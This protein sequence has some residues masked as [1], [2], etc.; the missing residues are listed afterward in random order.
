MTCLPQALLGGATAFAVF[1][2]AVPGAQAL[3]PKPDETEK[4]KACEA[5][6]CGVILNKGP[7]AGNLSCDL[8]KTWE[9]SR[10]V[11]GV[12]EKKISWTFGDAQCS[13]ALSVP[14]DTIVAALTKP[15]HDLDIA[16]H[17]VTCQ[18]ERAEEVTEVKI[19][20]APKIAFKEGKAHKAWLNVKQIDAPTVLKGAIWTV[21]KLEDNFG[22]FHSSMIKEIN[23]FVHNK[24]ERRHKK[25]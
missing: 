16:S 19:E 8:T 9:K 22:L 25:T 18:I 21:T 14:N 24:C 1:V 15:A 7:T 12:K 2:L 13:V 17:S 23:R 4:L 3:S 5:Q 20:M 10:I 11:D 6:L